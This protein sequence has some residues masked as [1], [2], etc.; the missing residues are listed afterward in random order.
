MALD[1]GADAAEEGLAAVGADPDV[2]GVRPDEG[3]VVLRRVGAPERELAALH[4]AEA[5]RAGVLVAEALRVGRVGAV[6]RVVDLLDVGVEGGVRGLVVA[7]REEHRERPAGAEQVAAARIRD[8]LADP[9]DGRGGVDEVE[10][11]RL[12]RNRRE[13][14]ADETEVRVAGELALADRGEV[15]A[16][17]DGRAV[18]AR[19]QRELRRLPGARA[20][21]QA[22]LSR[23]ERGPRRDAVEQLVAVPRP[24]AVERLGHGVEGS[25]GIGVH[26]RSLS[27][28]A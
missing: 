10:G 15:R 21:L 17:L 28:S 3:D 16:E 18:G 8:L 9:L 2:V 1:G 12:E 5:P 24:P 7:F 13:V 20:D 4:V 25:A 19:A 26:G 23:T 11:R 6:P 14:A 22:P 27:I